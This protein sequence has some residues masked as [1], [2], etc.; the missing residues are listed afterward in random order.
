MRSAIIEEIYNLMKENGNVYFLT[1]D[2]GYDVLEKIEAEFPN[3]FYNM[4]V[5][6]QNMIGVASGLALS[7]KKVFVFSITPFV[8]MRCYEQI[9]NDVCFHD[10]DITILG[11]GS[12]LSYG[13]LSST[14]F[15]L[16]DIAIL[17]PLPNMTIFS[18]VDEIEARLGMRYFKNHHHPLY[19]RIGKKKEEIIYKQP[20]DFQYGKGVII[21]PGKDVV[22]FATGPIIGEALSAADLLKE[23]NIEA[24]IINLH[25]IKPLDNDLIISESQGKKLIITLEEHGI[26]GGLGSAV[27]EVIG[28]YLPGNRVMRFGVEDK[29]INIV[30][31]Q[32]FLRKQFCLDSIGIMDTILKELKTY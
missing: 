14:H 11:I 8:T 13:I 7:G 5:A 24:E 28:E 9:R 32:T 15:S 19:I 2:L 12:G 30:G 26:I 18:P 17:R 4:G 10:L 29:P 27:S 1:G 3:R 25:T 22:I 21:R 20:Y 31:S 6:E 23:K 16:E